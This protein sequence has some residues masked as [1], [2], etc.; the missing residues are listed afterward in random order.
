MRVKSSP[1]RLQRCRLAGKKVHKVINGGV[2]KVRKAAKEAFGD[3]VLMRPDGNCLATVLLDPHQPAIEVRF[4]EHE[5]PGILDRDN[6]W[7][8]AEVM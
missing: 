3:A 5:G 1:Q 8:R 4:K 6:K 2:G 7:H